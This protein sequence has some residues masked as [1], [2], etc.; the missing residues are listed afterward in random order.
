[1]WFYIQYFAL[2]IFILIIQ[3]IFPSIN[4]EGLKLS[5]DLLLIL[6][7][8]IAFKSERFTCVIIAFILG[9][10]QDFISHIELIGIYSLSKSITGFLIS[11]IILKNY[12]LSKSILLLLI[13][14]VYIIHF[15]IYFYIVLNDSLLTIFIKIK[16][17]LIFS[18]VNIFLLFIVEN[19][20][21][22]KTLF[23]R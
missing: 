8:L 4:I 17:T 9:L 22:K 2:L 18:F 19:I 13:F 1:M 12:S 6:L 11:T 14:L 16:L 23:N 3:V 10:L 7:T 15:A 20:I 21:Y 5:P